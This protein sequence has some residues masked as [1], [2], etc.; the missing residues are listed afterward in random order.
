MDQKQEKTVCFTGHRTIPESDFARLN[1]ILTE[2]IQKQIDLGANV[3]RTGGARGFDTMAALA[4]LSLKIQNPHIRLHL[5][6]PC[7]TQTKGW[8]KNDVILYE[9]IAERADEVHYASS[10]YFNGLLQLRNRQLVDGADVCIAYLRDSGGGGTGYTSALAIK[11]GLEYIN[12]QE[13]L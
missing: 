2:Q 11:Q 7:P 4:I 6:L 10:F 5:M 12:L 8:E 3:F 13:M 9:Q 1:Q